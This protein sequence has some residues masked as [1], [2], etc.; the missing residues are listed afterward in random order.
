M[1]A[2]TQKQLQTGG[3]HNV[4]IGST[5]FIVSSHFNEK[6]KENLS[7]KLIRLVG[8]EYEKDSKPEIAD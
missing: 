5:T 4:R 2:L 8:K 1:S 3:Q 6:S 7:S